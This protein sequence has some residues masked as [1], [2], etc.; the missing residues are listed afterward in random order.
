MDQGH[1]GQMKRSG[2]LGGVWISMHLTLTPVQNDLFWLIVIF[3][4]GYLNWYR[5]NH[6]SYLYSL[7]WVVMGW[8][9][10]NTVSLQLT[11]LLKTW[12]E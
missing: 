3:K 11:P 7:Y 8:I 5:R 9:L 1:R 10:T 2:G 4:L 6:I 12:Y